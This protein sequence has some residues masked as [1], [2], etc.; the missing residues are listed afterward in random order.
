MALV[1]N[2][3][4]IGWP[5]SI[6]SGGYKGPTDGMFRSSSVAFSLKF[7]YLF[8]PDRQVAVK[9]SCSNDYVDT[10]IRF[11]DLEALA[12]HRGSLLGQEPD[13][14]QPSQKLFESRLFEALSYLDLKTNID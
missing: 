8:L 13:E 7:N 9:P 5:V 11:L 10:A 12:R 14:P 2:E 6:I 1:M 4:V 3:S